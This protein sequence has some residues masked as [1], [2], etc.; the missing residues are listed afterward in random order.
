M[1]SAPEFRPPDLC[2]ILTDAVFPHRVQR[3]ARSQP[4]VARLRESGVLK[5]PPIVTQVGDGMRVE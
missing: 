5:N 3:H 2:F 4:L 1:T